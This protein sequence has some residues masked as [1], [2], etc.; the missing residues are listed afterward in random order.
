MSKEVLL[1]FVDYE[2][3]RM[4]FRNYSEYI[5]IDDIVRAFEGLGKELGD[6]RT[7]FFY[8][9]W[10][11]RPQDARR[12]EDYGHRAKNVLSTRFGK[13][14]SDFPLGFDMYDHAREDRE[15]TAFILG[16]GD[17]G[18]KEAILR[19]RQFGKRI[20]VLC[21]GGSASRELFTL[22]HGV[23]PLES[24]LGLT[25]K[26]PLQPWMPGIPMKDEAEVTRALIGVI[27]SLEKSIPYIVRNYL[28][29]RVLLPKRL[30]GET[31]QEVQ[32]L[33]D[34]AISEGILIPEEVPNPKIE[35]R[36]IQI[37]RL[38]RGNPTVKE[39]LP[40]ANSEEAGRNPA[41]S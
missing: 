19:C 40:S 13:D 20:Y 26:P 6:L 16:S 11:R 23:Y 41:S 27:D 17:S 29:D 25:E 12:I 1:G 5:T 24:R 30:F 18:Y 28:R 32:E 9:D 15:V 21:F 3:L 8:G 35:G 36:T 4:A 14:R 38:N 33:L 31:W 22:T 34:K 7:I 10:T 39:V 37:V 2:N